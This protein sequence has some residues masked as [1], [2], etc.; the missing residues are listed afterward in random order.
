[1]RDWHRFVRANLSLPQLTAGR[2]ARIIREI[3]AQLEDFY[4]EARARGATGDEADAFARAQID[5][6]PRMAREL[7]LANRR[8]ERP[9][10]E[11]FA[12]SLELLAHSH[13]KRGALTMLAHVLTDMRYGM[14]QLLKTPGFTIVAVLTLAVGIGATSAI[15][16]VINGVAL[17]PLPFAEPERLVRVV[18]VVP[19]YG[20]FAVA[21]ANFLDWR[22]RNHVF[23]RLAAYAGGNDT[24]IGGDGPERIP[25]ALVSW[26]T[27]ELRGVRPA[28]G[29]GF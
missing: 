26:D 22:E 13:P 18:E 20:R 10:T 11:R 29:R 5:D 6:W 15:F 3:A 1:V 2:E 21:P 28:L 17:R 27:F 16:S 8:H 19:Q 24:F 7:S 12:G 23:E 9:R 14:R 4:R 25:R